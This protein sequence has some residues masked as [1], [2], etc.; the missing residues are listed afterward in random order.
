MDWTNLLTKRDTRINHLL[1]NERALTLENCTIRLFRVTRQ[2]ESI[3]K[4]IVKKRLSSLVSRAKSGI[5]T[6]TFSPSS[7]L[8]LF[9]F[10]HRQ[11]QYCHWRERLIGSHWTTPAYY[12][13]AFACSLLTSLTTVTIKTKLSMPKLSV[14]FYIFVRW[15][16]SY[17]SSRRPS[18][19]SSYCGHALALPKPFDRI[20]PHTIWDFRSIPLILHT[21]I[22]RATVLTGWNVT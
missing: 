7:N 16:I 10:T 3:E 5:P 20:E 11:R 22:G 8:T 4:A 14:N 2:K 12:N 6:S 9:S 15:N 19:N 1:T 18:Q 17:G 21:D 13:H